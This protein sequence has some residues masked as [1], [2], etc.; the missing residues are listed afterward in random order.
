MAT[1]PPAQTPPSA[2]LAETVR[3]LNRGLVRTFVGVAVL[4]LGVEVL[5]MFLVETQFHRHQVAHSLVDAAVLILS[6]LPAIYFLIFRP[7]KQ[8]L[9]RQMAAEQSVREL[10]ALNESQRRESDRRLM[11]EAQERS[12]ADARIQ[13]QARI[14]AVVQQAVVA[15]GRGGA[16]L[17]WNRYAEW[18][19]GWSEEEVKDQ[20]LAKVTGFTAEAAR[21][22][23]SGFGAVKGWTGEV[24]ALRR[25]GSSFPAFLTCSPI[26]RGDGSVAG[27]VYTFLDI[28]DRKAAEVA[29]RDSEDKYS[30]VVENS[31]IGV[32]IY[33]NGRLAFAN[34]RFFQMVGRSMRELATLDPAELIH[35]ED[36]P[37]IMA[38]WR[39]RLSGEPASQDN[40]SRILHSSGDIRWISGRTTL[41]R[42]GGEPALLGTIQDV[43]E[44]HKAEQ[45]LR[46]SREALHRLSAKL[47]SAQET[48]RRRVAQELH[49]SVGQSLS[50]VKFMVEQ[51]LE[52]LE[53]QGV[54]LDQ[55]RGLKA[56]VPVIQGA[57]EEVRRISMALRP[58]TLDD[59]GLLATIAWFTRE[60]M[61]TYP[62]FQV[63]R[64]VEVEEFEVPENLKTNI[65]RILQEAMNNAA[66]YS[67]AS[68]I[69]V[70]LRQVFGDLQLVVGDDGVGFDPSESRI[71]PGTNSGGY[72][73]V[74]MR[75]RAEL[76]GGSLILTSSPEEGTMVLARWPLPDEAIS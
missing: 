58:T 48:E 1:H 66:K 37:V 16:I 69:T 70:A 74:S 40:E 39:A 30:T 21:T 34:Q 65:F 63:D 59:L 8:S 64:L 20:T 27:F 15:T 19:F 11:A 72:G 56:A 36:W 32:F 29:I 57:V 3:A 33:R 2:P 52:S 41:I 49:D 22:G 24:K 53:A 7:M 31:P 4:I 17:Y 67:R 46:D 47:M 42:Y 61:N 28:T 44:R 55:G 76:F 6:T 5:V 73:L 13:F 9:Q 60:F 43:T 75:E 10:E 25:D 51:A 35:P 50:A 68:R 45:A 12:K 14:L 23:L 71:T 54:P 38:R 62:H 26:W 18:M